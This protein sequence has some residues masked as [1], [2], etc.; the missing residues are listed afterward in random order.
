MT[1]GL[2]LQLALARQQ[3]DDGERVYE[4]LVV[5]IE[6]VI[7]VV[8]LLGRV[9]LAPRHEGVPE[10]APGRGSGSGEGRVQRGPH[11]TYRRPND[12]M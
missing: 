2:G 4:A 12:S 10:P 11:E 8:N 1:L 5:H 9:P 6:L 3:L 7:G